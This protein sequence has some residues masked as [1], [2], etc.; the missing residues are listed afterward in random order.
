MARQRRRGK[1]LVTY[2]KPMRYEVADV[3]VKGYK[4]AKKLARMINVEVK[5]HDTLSSTNI[6]NAGNLIELSN[7][8]QNNTDE[9]RGGSS[10]KYKNI[11]LKYIL[12]MSLSATQ[13]TARVILFKN[14]REVTPIVSDILDNVSTVSVRD[15]QNRGHYQIISDKFFTFDINGKTQFHVDEWHKLF[16][17]LQFENQST[18]DESGSLWLLLICDEVTNVP[19]IK[20]ESRIQ[21]FDN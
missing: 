8:Q 16:G 4:L 14:K 13:S 20:L 17:H 1:Q 7:I 12:K 11:Q 6:S 19:V 5:H 10:V 3:A 18:T 21:F 9:G 2:K 15:W